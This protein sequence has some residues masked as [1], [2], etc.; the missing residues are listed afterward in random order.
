MTIKKLAN[1]VENAKAVLD[2]CMKTFTCEPEVDYEHHIVT[3]NISYADP[4]LR[5]ANSRV[6]Y[7]DNEHNYK[8]GNA[9]FDDISDRSSLEARCAQYSPAQ[10]KWFDTYKA[11]GN[12]SALTSLENIRNRHTSL[13]PIEQNPVDNNERYMYVLY[14][15]PEATK[16]LL[17]FEYCGYW[18]M[19]WHDENNTPWYLDIPTLSSRMQVEVKGEFDKVRK[20]SDGDND[21][22]YNLFGQNRNA[23]DVLNQV[24]IPNPTRFPYKNKHWYYTHWFIHLN[25]NR[26]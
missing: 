25:V 10:D 2:E 9:Q 8:L 22:N 5:I 4:A 19:D 3:F 24:S 15:E 14:Q 26:W 11:D 17:I 16:Y 18:H 23:F 21:F 20:L 12:Y 6:I 13:T 1:T 7:N